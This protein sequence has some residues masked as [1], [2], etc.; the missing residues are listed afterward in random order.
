MVY[1]SKGTEDKTLETEEST[2][3]SGIWQM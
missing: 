1:S 3:C 2:N